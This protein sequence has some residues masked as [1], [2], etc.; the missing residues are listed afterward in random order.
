MKECDWQYFLEGT[1]YC[2][3]PGCE[4]EYQG[5]RVLMSFYLPNSK[6]EIKGFINT[7]LLN[8]EYDLEDEINKIIVDL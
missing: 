7:C 6:M 2:K 4:C 1:Q 8:V 5:Q 3:L